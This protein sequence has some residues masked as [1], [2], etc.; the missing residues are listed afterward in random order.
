MLCDFYAL[1]L[2][3]IE[4]HVQPLSEV[5]RGRWLEIVVRLT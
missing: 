1:F 2:G 4:E 5:L 3:G